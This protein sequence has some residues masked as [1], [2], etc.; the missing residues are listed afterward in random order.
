M[1]AYLEL[2][3]EQGV[4][5]KFYEVTVEGCDLTIRYG[6]IGTDG[7]SKSKTFPSEEK[8][9][10]EAN[11][12][13]GQKK[14]KGYD[15]AVMGV[16]QKRSVTRRQITSKKSTA[17]R[18]PVLWTFDSK[19]AA[20]GIFVG[21]DGCWVGNEDGD[22]YALD[23]EGNATR[24][25]KLPD[26][27]KCI[28][29]DGEWLYAGCDDGNVYDLTGKMPFA[30]YEISTDVDIYWLD[31]ADGVLGVAD[32]QGYVHVFN[33]EDVTQWKGKSKGNCGWMVRC[34]EIGV[35]HGHSKGITM[36]DWED[37]S[38]IWHANTGG[39]VLFGWQEESTVYAGCNDN[40]VYRFTKQGEASG[41]AT[42]DASVFSCA[43]TEDGKFIFAGDNCS[44]IYCFDQEGNRL[45]KMAT[46]A[47]S[48]Y[49][50]Q[51][52]N[53]R[54]YLVTTTG[55]LVCIDAREEAITAA[56]QG[57]V[58]KARDIKAASAPAAAAAGTMQNVETTSNDGEGVV[59]EC[60][61]DD[62][63][64]LRMRVVSDGFDSTW[65]LQFP[66]ALR[67]DGAR[68]VVD[69]VLES[70]RGGFYRAKGNIKKLV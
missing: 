47:G 49:S 54:L 18:A 27:V 51:F 52:F 68:F 66:R 55:A 32:D 17:K 31:I 19:A 40:K 34:D 39:A 48:A 3:E 58:P 22:I 20:F 21:E 59:V 43:A 5:H 67:E 53:E 63:G 46:N 65:K 13:I 9:L 26:G 15:D 70:A 24:H 38:E 62:G 41:V 33:H 1:K 42:C 14:R 6:R 4:S 69:E 10:A 30:A 57:V 36:Y 60:F 29:S 50:M 45:W 56:E 64:K 8:A 23:H 11:K 28:V 2:S 37:G 61:K 12:K 35:Y 7:T 25:F 16:R 44:S